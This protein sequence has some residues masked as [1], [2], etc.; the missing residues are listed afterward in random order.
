[1]TF[2]IRKQN[3]KFDNVPKN[4]YANNPVITN[5]WNALSITFPEGEMY[6]VKSV[7]QFE[8]FISDTTLKTDI[9][10]FIGQEAMH[11]KEHR[12]LNKM[13]FEQGYSNVYELEDM[14]KYLLRGANKILPGEV[15]L[16]ITCA[17]EH[18]TAILAEQLLTN[19]N[20]Q[21][22]ICQD[23]KK[24]WLWHALEESEHKHVAFDVYNKLGG[25]YIVRVLAM[26]LATFILFAVIS[27]F[28]VMLLHKQGKLGSIFAWQEAFDYLWKIN[29]NKP[30]NQWGLFS[31]LIIPWLKYFKY[32]FHPNDLDTPEFIAAKEKVLK[33]IL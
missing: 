24:L 1:M 26:L 10:N 17:L 12:A 27:W 22:N 23:L 3:F 19:K 18:F 28:Q 6:F 31:S 7:K 14:V 5:M 4:W 29:L 20:H 30:S 32:N 15:N 11:G 33:T 9:K 2:P 16:A 21:E 13:L 25:F 8:M